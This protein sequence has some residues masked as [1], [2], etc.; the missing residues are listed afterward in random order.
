MNLNELAKMLGQSE[1]DTAGFIAGLSV[2]V[3]KGYSIEAAISK[4]MET[5]TRLANN[6][7]KFSQTLSKDAAF[8]NGLHASLQ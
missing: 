6:A 3:Q 1:T 2:W 8:V 7:V 5:M 4:H